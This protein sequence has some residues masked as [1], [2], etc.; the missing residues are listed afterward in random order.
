VF[1]DL[2]QGY[3]PTQQQWS[4]REVSPSTGSWTTFS[5]THYT[6][7][8]TTSDT[9]KFEVRL[10]STNGDGCTDEIIKEVTVHPQVVAD[11]DVDIMDGCSP[12]EVKFTNN[13]VRSGVEYIWDWSDGPGEVTTTEA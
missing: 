8:N 3:D 4:Y 9:K 12:M 11:F 7:E 2:S 5:G 13:A 1:T 6:F 10:Q